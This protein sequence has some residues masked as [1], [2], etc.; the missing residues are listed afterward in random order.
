MVTR[1]RKPV[2]YRMKRGK[3]SLLPKL[4]IT[5]VLILAAVFIFF[6]VRRLGNPSARP[7]NLEGYDLPVF[8]GSPS[9]SDTSVWVVP[10]TPTVLVLPTLA[11]E[12]TQPV[13]ESLPTAVPTL[14]LALPTAVPE[15]VPA[16]PR[17]L[18]EGLPVSP[19]KGYDWQGLY[20]QVVISWLEEEN[21]SAQ[22]APAVPSG[23]LPK[24]LV[25]WA[26]FTLGTVL[27]VVLAA[28]V[29][30]VL[31]WQLG[32]KILKWAV[33]GGLWSF[34]AALALKISSELGLDLVQLIKEALAPI[35]KAT[36]PENALQ[37]MQQQSLAGQVAS[38]VLLVIVGLVVLVI[39]WGAVS[40]LLRQ[41]GQ[42]T[43]ELRQGLVQVYQQVRGTIDRQ[44]LV[45]ALVALIAV[46]VFIALLSDTWRDNPVRSLAYFFVLISGGLGLLFS[47]DVYGEDLSLAAQQAERA[48]AFNLL[49]PDLVKIGRI[50][51]ALA[52]LVTLLSVSL[53]TISGVVTEL[54]GLDVGKLLDPKLRELFP[55]AKFGAYIMTG[56]W[57]GV[58]WLRRGN[59]NPSVRRSRPSSRRPFSTPPPRMSEASSSQPSVSQPG[60]QPP[61]WAAPHL[62]SQED[63]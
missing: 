14:V 24:R 20:R 47:F 59:S 51:W 2:R 31:A 55:L 34:L 25:P 36:S 38:L 56:V 1:P 43:Q 30:G 42:R 48:G 19:R 52:M 39:I 22:M 53:L 13:V 45:V 40:Y 32:A 15:Q 35:T 28:V 54:L 50:F 61:S 33:R 29:V 46:A 41:A 8:G 16:Q 58:V 26:R 23:P 4:V 21:T 6:L 11:L 17:G 12:V 60:G 44:V 62:G 10:V 27:L 18:P 37:T 7:N 57:V 3:V 49:R 63:L 5:G 9:S